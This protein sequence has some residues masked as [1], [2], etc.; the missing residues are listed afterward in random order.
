M[1]NTS[2]PNDIQYHVYS[3][4]TM[5]K[6]LENDTV[7]VLDLSG[8]YDYEVWLCPK[9]K[10]LYIFEPFVRGEDKPVKYIYKLESET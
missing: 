6:I 4:R 10:R 3:D 2:C 5:D 8:I 1:S 7:D 9:C